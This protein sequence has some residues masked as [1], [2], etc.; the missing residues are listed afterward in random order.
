M[1]TDPRQLMQ[2]FLRISYMYARSPVSLGFLLVVF[3]ASNTVE[4]TALEEYS[5]EKSISQRVESIRKRL[6]HASPEQD[7]RP[8]TLA[9]WNNWANWG[10]WRNY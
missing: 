3:A 10:N 1:K 5:P 2:D 6:G 9:Q 4:S 7:Q 8:Q